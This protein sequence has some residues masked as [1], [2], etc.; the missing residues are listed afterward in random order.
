MSG[1]AVP[2]FPRSRAWIKIASA[3]SATSR[4]E[5]PR[6]SAGLGVLVAIDV[7][8]CPPARDARS[9]GVTS[10]AI[11]DRPSSENRPHL[12]TGREAADPRRE[13]GEVVLVGHLA[14]SAA[15]AFDGL[16]KKSRYVS[17]LMRTVAGL[18]GRPTG[19][20]GTPLTR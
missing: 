18:P 16:S 5:I 15:V 1:A 10:D 9:H 14:P 19:R 13:A 3:N 11:C 20:P 2:K 7:S 17:R 12:K 6:V 8:G 4:R